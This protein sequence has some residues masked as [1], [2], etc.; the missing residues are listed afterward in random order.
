MATKIKIKFNL[1]FID[2]NYLILDLSS[3]NPGKIDIGKGLQLICTFETHENQKFI[4]VH[5]NMRVINQ[6][7]K[8]LTFCLQN[9]T[10]ENEKEDIS[11]Q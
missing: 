10:K 11:L 2:K 7:E 9:E 8:N 4:R 3:Q 1:D 5:S 6:V